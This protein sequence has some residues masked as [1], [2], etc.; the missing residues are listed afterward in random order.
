MTIFSGF[1]VS[2]VT[3]QQ[4]GSWFQSQ[5]EL[6]C[7]EHAPPMFALILSGY[8]IIQSKNIRTR[9]TDDSELSIEMCVSVDDCERPF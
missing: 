4:E 6:L 9:S 3:S 2:A 5:L 7:V 1:V 8:A